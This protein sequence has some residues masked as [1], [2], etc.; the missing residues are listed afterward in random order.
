MISFLPTL[1]A[2]STVA[3]LKVSP[4]LTDRRK[5]TAKHL[6]GSRALLSPK[7]VIFRHLNCEVFSPC[8]KASLYGT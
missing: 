6:G 7:F 2:S 1:Q 4:G 5:L 8:S 3:R